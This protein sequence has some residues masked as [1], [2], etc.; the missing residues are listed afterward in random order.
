[1]NK[2]KKLI[3]QFTIGGKTFGL[4]KI[5]LEQTSGTCPCKLGANDF[6]DEAEENNYLDNND[7]PLTQLR[8]GLDYQWSGEGD[9]LEETPGCYESYTWDGLLILR[10]GNPYD[11][12]TVE[13]VVEEIISDSDNQ[14]IQDVPNVCRVYN[15]LKKIKSDAEGGSRTCQELYTG[16]GTKDAQL[17]D[18]MEK[19]CT[20]TSKLWSPPDTA[21]EGGLKSKQGY[22]VFELPNGQLKDVLH[23]KFEDVIA[24]ELGLDPTNKTSS[25]YTNCISR[26]TVPY[27]KSDEWFDD[28]RKKGPVMGSYKAFGVKFSCLPEESPYRGENLKVINLNHPLIN[29]LYGGNSNSNTLDDVSNDTKTKTV[30]KKEKVDIEVEN[31]PGNYEEF[32]WL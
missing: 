8:P 13:K 15:L 14:T 24:I 27:E 23:R 25:T 29:R 32:D 17:D 22:V 16:D 18:W 7:Q 30:N 10:P 3:E 21:E 6:K 5:L 19:L 1:M 11:G 12:R 4:A 28:G 31:Q 9:E 20:I 2:T 26:F